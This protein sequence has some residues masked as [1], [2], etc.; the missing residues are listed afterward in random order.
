MDFKHSMLIFH[1]IWKKNHVIILIIIYV[2]DLTVIKKIIYMVLI[3]RTV[4]NKHFRWRFWYSC[5]TC[6]IS[7]WSNPQMG[8]GYWHIP[9]FL[10][11]LKCESKN[12]N[13]ERRNCGTFLSSQHFRGKGAC[14]SSRMG[15]KMSDKRINYSQKLA[16]TKQQVG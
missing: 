16:Q 13:N 9:T 6:F 11:K 2:D 1:F 4:W 5:I 7:R 3:L 15:T 14:W 10:E 12:G 8:Y